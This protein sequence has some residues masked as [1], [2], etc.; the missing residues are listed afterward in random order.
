VAF[1]VAV[2]DNIKIGNKGI[3]QY[4]NQ[5]IDNM[6]F[7]IKMEEFFVDN[8]VGNLHKF[9]GKSVE[10]KALNREKKP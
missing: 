6:S 9:G 4:I 10:R 7:T 2:K 1:N 8:F 3:G 5:Y